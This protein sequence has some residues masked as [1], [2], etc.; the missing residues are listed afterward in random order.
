M[1]KKA[2]RAQHDNGGHEVKKAV[3]RLVS[4]KRRNISPVLRDFK[5]VAHASHRLYELDGL[6][7]IDLLRRRR[8]ATSITLVS[9]SKFMSHT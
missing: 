8:T 1:Q 4:E 2:N 7:V 9:L 6:A 5:H 3:R